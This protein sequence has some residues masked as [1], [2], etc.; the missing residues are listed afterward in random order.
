[1][2][3]SVW[4]WREQFSDQDILLFYNPLFNQENSRDH[5][6]RFIKPL[7]SIS[8]LELWSQCY[9]RWIPPLEIHSGGR[10]HIE[11][12]TRLVQNDVAQLKVNANGNCGSPVEKLT[13]Y[14][15]QMNIDSFYPFS[16][17]RSG[18]IV[19]TPI[20]NSSMLMNESLLDAQSLLTAPD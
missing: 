9:F 7:Y 5:G 18:N 14:L 10:N 20:M 13:T 2:L 6:K 11:L 16:N 4:D 12:Y 8:S 15:V 1:M 19:S 3:R 17:K